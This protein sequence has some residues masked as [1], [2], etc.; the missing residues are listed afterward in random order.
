MGEETF[1][2]KDV[3]QRLVK[4]LNEQ[5]IKLDD[6]RIKKSHENKTFMDHVRMLG[7]V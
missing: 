4:W 7:V 6:P 5:N 3:L 2:V 1:N